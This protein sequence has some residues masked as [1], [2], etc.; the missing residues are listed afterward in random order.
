MPPPSQFAPGSGHVFGNGHIHRRV[1]S[2][3]DA[4]PHFN[5]RLLPTPLGR[6]L[7]PLVIF[8][9]CHGRFVS[10]LL[11]F[12]GFVTESDG[13]DRR[14]RMASSTP[15]VKSLFNS[16][17]TRYR[18][19]E[20]RVP[21]QDEFDDASF[22]SRSSRDSHTGGGV[23]EY[24]GSISDYSNSVN[25]YSL[26]DHWINAATPTNVHGGGFQNGLPPRSMVSQM[27]DAYKRGSDSA[28]EAKLREKLAA[29]QRAQ[30][31]AAARAQSLDLTSLGMTS[32]GT[33]SRT[34][35]GE[36]PIDEATGGV[37]DNA[38]RESSS[39]PPMSTSMTS[40]P[41]LN[42][43]PINP[44]NLMGSTKPRQRGGL[45]GAGRPVLDTDAVTTDN[46]HSMFASM[47][48]DSP[49]R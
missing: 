19:P 40:F 12:N 22:Y 47:N 8:S 46:M 49:I 7:K 29:S 31:T 25:D 23:Q 41:T 21:E 28:I 20:Q 35:L 9:R 3:T 30:H 2:F 14:I 5:S 16:P 26:N 44:G 39:S 11:T 17:S 1:D 4:F 10:S 38:A 13:L 37:E 34:S 24:N 33:A 36:T 18:A 32:R 15:D 6:Y 48:L 45:V 43:P 27:D 42:D